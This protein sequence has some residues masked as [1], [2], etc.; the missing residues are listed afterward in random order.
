MK[1]ALKITFAKYKALC[2]NLI[3][4]GGSFA[5]FQNESIFQVREEGRDDTTIWSCSRNA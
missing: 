4:S 1:I 5:D 2:Y 3:K